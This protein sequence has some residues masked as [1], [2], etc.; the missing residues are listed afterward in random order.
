[1]TAQAI[2][3][4]ILPKSQ[5][6]AIKKLLTKTANDAWKLDSAAIHWQ[7]TFCHRRKAAKIE[8]KPR[9]ISISI[10]VLSIF[11]TQLGQNGSNLPDVNRIPFVPPNGARGCPQI[12]G[13]VHRVDGFPKAR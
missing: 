8:Q 9:F 7:H 11:W 5:F 10:A 1:L 3:F 13:D 12:A 4:S 2:H 6:N